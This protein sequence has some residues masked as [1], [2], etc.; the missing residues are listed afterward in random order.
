MSDSDLNEVRRSVQD[1]C[2][3]INFAA[4]ELAKVFKDDQY[5][6]A[7]LEDNKGHL[8]KT[9]AAIFRALAY[10]K[11]YQVYKI[12]PTDAAMELYAWNSK[13]GGLP[14][15]SAHFDDHVKCDGYVD[16][17]GLSFQSIDT[18]L[19]RKKSS[20]ADTCF[21]GLFDHLYIFGLPG[22]LTAV[23]RALINLLPSRYS[24]R[25]SFITLEKAKSR[26][27]RLEAVKRPKGSNIRQV[28]RRDSVHEDRIDQIL[29]TFNEAKKM[30]DKIYD[31]VFSLSQVGDCTVIQ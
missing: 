18:R 7:F 16:L 2:R 10:R 31:E 30:S 27:C 24:D 29:K 8:D 15:F 5:V 21:P 23:F 6:T 9:A 25:F 11:K 19:S 4:L 17:R 14:F 20:M 13:P 26:V 28:L 3:N 22:K 12:Q 1:K